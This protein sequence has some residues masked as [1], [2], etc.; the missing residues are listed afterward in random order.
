M[1]ATHNNE[2]KRDAVRI[3]TTGCLT[4]RQVASDCGIGIS[5][6]S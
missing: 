3:A 6:L 1:A 5:T 2:L 4:S